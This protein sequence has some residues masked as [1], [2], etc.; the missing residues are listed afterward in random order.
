MVR[1]A[2]GLLSLLLVAHGAD[3][4]Y[5]ALRS[6]TQSQM[7]CADFAQKG[8]SSAWLA[9]TGCEVDYV[10][11]GYREAPRDLF[12]RL[13]GGAA[14]P[15][16]VTELLFPVRPVGSNPT[17]PAALVVS[18]RDPNVL[19][20]AER[21]LSVRG[22]IDQEAF[23]VMMLQVVTAMR[24]SREIDG[25]VRAP[26][27]LL[28]SRGGLSAIRAPLT[29]RFAVL[30]LH[31]RPHVLLPVLE[32]V[33]GL[34]ALVVVFVRRRAVELAAGADVVYPRLML[35]NLPAS[36]TPQDLENAPPLGTQ[37]EVRQRLAAA[38]PGIAF[39]E[40]GKAHLATSHQTID[41]DL[42]LAD[43]VPTAVVQ[44]K[45]VATKTL[46]TL[47]TKTGWRAF[48]PRRGAFVGVSDLH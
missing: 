15:A 19:A 39:D 30:D 43:P 24:V 9:L 28:R 36:A 34:V 40:H 42:G 18:T 44:L 38:L 46:A 23:L 27:D 16:R 37:V 13:F 20:I 8:S 48:A 14:A 21:T 4:T 26:L 45:G 31:Q 17:V 11:A 32:V 41:I 35:L 7:T 3:G 25:T 22:T 47:L 2:L 5:R 6:R 12:G 29:D 10:H 33:A 1:I